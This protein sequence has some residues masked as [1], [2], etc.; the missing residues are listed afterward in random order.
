MSAVFVCSSFFP[1]VK[2]KLFS[3]HET[4][5]FGEL[6]K[7]SPNV[8]VVQAPKSLELGEKAILEVEIFP[9]IYRKWVS[10]HT[11][12]DRPHS[13]VDEQVAGEG[14]FLKFQHSHIFVD[15]D[16]GSILSDRIELDFPFLPISKFPIL[17]NLQSQ[18]RK[19]HEITAKSLGV[20]SKLLVC[21]YE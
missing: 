7:H 6:I 16:K 10:V 14:P 18:F 17:W 12:L 9:F 8:R 5:G 15:V 19:R 2:E 11:K 13:F 21:D 20:S 3:W 1:V 4:E